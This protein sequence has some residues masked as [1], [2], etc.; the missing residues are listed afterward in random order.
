MLK[1]QLEQL[2]QSVNTFI[3]D[4]EMRAENAEEQ[5]QQ[6]WGDTKKEL[7][8]RQKIAE[9]KIQELQEGGQEASEELKIGAQKAI[10]ELE[11]SFNTAKEKLKSSQ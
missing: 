9:D 2:K 10:Q 6:Y 8:D 7:Q 3:T 1:E 4:I 11:T 5:A